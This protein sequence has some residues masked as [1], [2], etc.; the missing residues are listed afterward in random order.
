MS[1]F[2]LLPPWANILIFIAAAALV[3]FAGVRLSSY[4]EVIS[5][6][7]GVGKAF[8]GALMLGGVTALPEAATT[9]TAS[10]VKN[11]PLAL[12]NIFGGVAMQ[13]GILALMD[14]TI[15]NKAASAMVAGRSILL[16]GGILMTVLAIA[17]AGI[18]LGD[19]LF[20]EVGFWSTLVLITS[21]LGFYLIHRQPPARS[22]R[23]SDSSIERDHQ[24]RA[25]RY[26][27]AWLLAATIGSAM[28]IV[29]GGFLLASTA[30]IIAVQTGIG[31]NFVGAVF[32]AIASSLPEVSTTLSA[33]R[34]GQFT[35][36]FS[37]IFGS[38]IIDVSIL[39]LADAV[40]PGGP[41]LNQVGI[42]S[43]TT[44]LLGMLLTAIYIVGI[45]RKQV[46]VFAHLGLDSWLVMVL[47][48]L[49]I[50]VLYK[51]R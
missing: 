30:D 29:A 5:D 15:R 6:R 18:G 42:F 22:N 46:P 1:Q 48:I 44:V 23:Q 31:S 27:Y 12:N 33:A 34:L 21:L 20:L 4:A 28:L 39:F 3:W 45:K 24:N 47:Y 25:R 8:I 49:G 51:L 37:N 13:V 41:V 43:I 50:V 17:A 2:E 19:I 7:T 10:V 9:V 14:A 26:S 16:Q 11:A 40:Y 38:N 36:A 35:M 32:I